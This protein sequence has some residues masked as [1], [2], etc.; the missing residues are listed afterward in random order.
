[1]SP[2]SPLS[3]SYLCLH[4]SLALSSVSLLLS[5]SVHSAM[6]CLLQMLTTWPCGLLSS[7]SFL[8]PSTPPSLNS[9]CA[10]SQPF[11]D[12]WADTKPS[13]KCPR[14]RWRPSDNRR[15]SLHAREEGTRERHRKASMLML[16]WSSA[17]AAAGR[18]LHG[19]VER[20]AAYG[21][22]QRGDQQA[23]S[24]P[25]WRCRSAVAA[26]CSSRSSRTSISIQHQ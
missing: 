10:T 20:L 9:S 21:D 25:S 22:P 14:T 18:P 1:M 4:V 12:L 7:K 6:A 15:R 3:P 19:V 13:M 23:A 26:G 17:A 8:R 24:S 16:C 2:S 5:F 11:V